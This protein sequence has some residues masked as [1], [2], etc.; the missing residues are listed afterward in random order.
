MINPLRLLFVLVFF[1]GTTLGSIGQ[2]IN[3]NIW[4]FGDCTPTGRTIL[5][6]DPIDNEA[7]V[8]ALDPTAIAGQQTLG[9]NTI[10]TVI[11]QASGKLL[12]YSNGALFINGNH[13]AVVG[14]NLD[15]DET[16]PQSVAI[17][18]GSFAQDPLVT[19]N[20]FIFYHT[21]G[22]NLG[23][24]Q[25]EYNQSFG[26]QKV[27]GPNNSFRSNVASVIELVDE[28][29]PNVNNNSFLFYYDFAAGNLH[30]LHIN[31]VNPSAWP[32]VSVPLLPP[33]IVP[34]SIRFNEQSNQVAV[35][36]ST[37]EVAFVKFDRATRSFD[38]ASIILTSLPTPTA[39]PKA[40]TF[41]P[42]GTKSY[43]TIG[44]E[45]YQIDL[46][47]GPNPIPVL[48]PGITG[49]Q[50]LFDVQLAP[51]GK[52]YFLYSPIGS[53]EVKLGE[54]EIP[55]LAATDPGFIVNMD[56][57][58]SVN[59]CGKMFPNFSTTVYIT[60]TVDIILPPLPATGEFCADNPIQLV[61]KITPANLVPVSFQWTVSSAVPT[62]PTT[63]PSSG[64]TN[65]D[66]A[67]LILAATG[68]ATVE[69]VVT[70]KDHPPV[71]A[72]SQTVNFST[73]P[74]PDVQLNPNPYEVVCP[75]QNPK[76]P[77]PMD[78]EGVD[79]S[80]WLQVDGN[81]APA[82]G[83][84]YFWSAF[85][86][87]GWTPNPE[88]KVCEPG[89]YYVMVR[90]LGELCYGL[91]EV[92]VEVVDNAT[93]DG[94]EAG[95][96]GKWFFGDKAGIDF[97]TFPLFPSNVT[98][99]APRPLNVPA[100]GNLAPPITIQNKHPQTIQYGV[101]V[102]YDVA[103]NVIFY[104]DGEKVWDFGHDPIPIDP[105]GAFPTL[106]GDK[107]ASQSTLIIPYP[108]PNQQTARSLFYIFTSEVNAPYR[109]KFS[110]LDLAQGSSTAASPGNYLGTVASSN[111]LLLPEATQQ[112]A[113]FQEIDKSFVAFKEMGSG[114][115]RVHKIDQ[116]GIHAPIFS[117]SGNFTPFDKIISG[118]LQFSRGGKYL[119]SVYSYLEAGVERSTVEVF[120][121]DK[122]TG[123]LSLSLYASFELPG[124]GHGIEISEDETRLFVSLDDSIREF[125]I[126]PQAPPPLGPTGISTSTNPFNTCF[127][128]SSSVL[129][130]SLCIKNSSAS[131][132]TPNFKYRSLQ[133]G[134]APANSVFVAVENQS[135]VYQI[136]EGSGLLNKSN[137]TPRLGMTPNSARVL[138]GLPRYNVPIPKSSGLDTPSLIGLN[139]MCLTVA[140]P[141]RPPV[142]GT[143][144]Y[145]L[146]ISGEDLDQHTFRFERE[147]EGKV[148]VPTGII[149]FQSPINP[150]D[151]TITFTQPGIYSIF[152][153][154]QRC[155]YTF[156]ELVKKVDIYA[157]PF[158]LPDTINFCDDGSPLEI[159]ALNDAFYTMADFEIEWR[160]ADPI[161]L[162]PFGPVISTDNKLVL[163]NPAGI[164]Q[165]VVTAKHKFR[166]DPC[167][168]S[169]S[170]FIGP[171]RGL[172]LGIVNSTIC[173]DGTLIA[174]PYLPP[175]PPSVSSGDIGTF[176][177]FKTGVIRKLV[178]EASNSSILTLPVK[179]KLPA[180]D[181]EL[182]FEVLDALAL[183]S[184]GPNAP[185]CL[186]SF[187]KPFTILP[188]PRIDFVVTNATDCSTATG[189][190]LLRNVDP[191]F[192]ITINGL[193][194]GSLSPTP[195]ANLAAREVKITGLSAG[196]YLVVV[197]NSGCD[198]STNILVRVATQKVKI[199]EFS[200][201]VEPIRCNSP[202]TK[203]QLTINFPAGFSGKYQIVNPFSTPSTVISGNVLPVSKK[204]VEY[205]DA[206]TY[207]LDFFD[208][209]NCFLTSFTFEVIDEIGK[210]ISL[211]QYFCPLVTP[212]PTI[213]LPSF[214]NLADPNITGVTWK[215]STGLILTPPTG[216]VFRAPSRGTYS[217][218]VDYGGCVMKFEINLLEQCSIQY[219]LP[220][221]LR[222]STSPKGRSGT[223]FQ[224]NVLTL[225]TSNFVKN[226]NAL[227]YN[228]WGQL[229]HVTEYNSQ[230]AEAS[231]NE[232]IWDGKVNGQFVPIGT[233]VV[234]L[235]L[236]DL[237]DK[238]EK[239]T[240]S[241]LVLS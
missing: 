178:Y 115:Y 23:F 167:P 69:L 40:I 43:V 113:G 203:G 96:N 62:T 97:N 52:V 39:Q 141:A 160:R 182:E 205:L 19:D 163:T 153:T 149:P 166:T 229:I 91:A 231:F 83:F 221:T 222:L 86:E 130:R 174:F 227:V 112:M 3:K 104:S 34:V 6:F 33:G 35:V 67:H 108:N 42:T 169:T 77:K 151:W 29:K 207:K 98:K 168:S 1:F 16:E 241:V 155:G 107:S 53:T 136:N 13:D 201:E 118:A 206:G 177:I 209:N 48:V 184:S 15:G 61:S 186:L 230:T 49:V 220:N 7:N 144:A 202:L 24:Q 93:G 68:T 156:D 38:P 84:E 173:F 60:P 171:P 214:L 32:D 192:N 9:T 90:R 145:A 63:P 17:A 150:T 4:I 161:T 199:P 85:P 139:E 109:V 154:V 208:A 238:V 14:S 157:P 111:H 79:L 106:G 195:I 41:D 180:G 12:F 101:D 185:K 142:T 239:F 223:N 65:F 226:V 181:Y 187:M 82:T 215:D 147:F 138:N 22:K 75:C 25:L 210:T 159:K 117:E 211:T 135:F 128:G 57:F 21:P 125:F 45:L 30:A 200:F 122:T 92:L 137:V 148:T 114:R 196:S 72:T 47:S 194:L 81:P 26:V 183:S 59:F 219:T 80:K 95:R 37:G 212:N 56:P 225:V 131:I 121:F 44:N 18:V 51:N 110:M 237:D 103:G 152:V 119:A 66:V 124:K 71:T 64:P 94:L 123:N 134:P 58:P 89:I 172:D 87:K 127:S 11:D 190:I 218:E 233:Y 213:E 5:N 8:I 235:F 216:T 170:V 217:L 236:T 232:V 132:G 189:E 99:S 88:A 55:S 198:F 20:Y 162:I 228:R 105:T 100:L 10:A 74:V 240:N 120:E 158:I 193:P 73:S 197:E 191:S 179:N 165:Y 146:S 224:D 27:G 28:A 78:N 164:G 204:T 133:R 175:S 54:I 176:R 126:E 76:N 188:E 2:G 70:F 36:S 46:L 31:G 234:V 140:P 102:F 129:A 116:D 143:A 50:E